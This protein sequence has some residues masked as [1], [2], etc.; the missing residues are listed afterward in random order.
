MRASAFHGELAGVT[1]DEEFNQ[2]GNVLGPLAQR[3][4]GNGDHA[5]AIEQIL[6]ELALVDGG[7]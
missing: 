7:F 5:E 4:Q 6:A 1:L 2:F 3:G